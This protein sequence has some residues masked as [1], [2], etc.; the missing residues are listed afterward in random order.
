MGV[1]ITTSSLA[2]GSRC[3][4]ARAGIGVVLTQHWTDPRLGPRGLAMLADGC[5]AAAVAAALA[6]ST[7][8]RDWRQLA[9]LDGA[10]GAG[11]FTGAQTKGAFGAAI[12]ADCV[13][14]GNIMRNAAIPAAMV[15]A[16]T[17]AG[18]LHLAERL[19]AAAD[20]GLAA[21]GE[22]KPLASAALLIVRDAPFPYADLRVDAAASPLEE[23]RRLWTLY[24]PEAEDYWGRAMTPERLAAGA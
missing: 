9:V 2:V 16:F 10:G 4:F 22:E 6:A 23:L 3:V 24:A 12:G 13:A 17:A 21:G 19:L 11:H 18:A 8:Q 20:A 7:P 5:P 14:A 1:V 15:A